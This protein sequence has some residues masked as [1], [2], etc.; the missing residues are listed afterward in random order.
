MK[1]KAFLI[2]ACALAGSPAL[3][4]AASP[5]LVWSDEFNQP[6]S[7]G[8]DTSKWIYDLGAGDPPGWG[9]E[10]LETYTD[11]RGNSFVA[12]DPSA[13]DGKALVIRAVKSGP[14]YTSARIKT[15]ATFQYVRLEARVRVPSGAGCWPAFWAVGGNLASVGWPD[16]GEIDVMEWVGKAPGRIKGSLH[17]PGFSGNRCLNAD[18]VLPNGGVYGDAYHVFAADWYPDEVVFS[19][20]GVVYEERRKADRPAGSKWPFDHP[21]QILLN[22][23]V[24]GGWPGNPDSSTV[25][26]QDY[27][28]DY[29]RVYSLPAT[30]P[31]NL[32]WPPTPPSGI[33][34]NSSGASGIAV[35][36][37]PPSTEFG[38]PLM[39]YK[40]QRASDPAFSRE[41]TTWSL[42]TSTGYTDTSVK[43]REAYYYR[44]FAVSADGS[45]DASASVVLSVP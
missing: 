32:V 41:L 34:A 14:A 8:P 1:R 42:G 16:C 29:V 15:R 22:F 4:R 20:D 17:A 39:G 27:R 44:V 2:L 38:A 26:P 28:V 3:V 21:F 33:A 36:W 23:A 37:Q 18:D 25:F 10:E 35:S 13:T 31:A 40:L 19:M 12:S 43:S 30:P 6:A 9:N 24:G 7:T 45:S 5:V 11:S